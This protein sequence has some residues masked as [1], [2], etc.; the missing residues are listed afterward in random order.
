MELAA[1]HSAGNLV[2]GVI[3]FFVIAIYSFWL[4]KIFDSRPPDRLWPLVLG[5]VVIFGF[6]TPT[7]MILG[8][9]QILRDGPVEV[10]EGYRVASIL[11]WVIR[12]AGFI[13]AG[14]IFIVSFMA[15]Q[16]GVDRGRMFRL[17]GWLGFGSLAMWALL[18]FVMW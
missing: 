5:V 18:T 7:T 16:D 17:G 3:G 1:I 15:A 14:L 4:V 9:S 8:L 13:A 6:L 12:G 2:F 11:F 10:F